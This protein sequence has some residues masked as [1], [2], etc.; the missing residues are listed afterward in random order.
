MSFKTV[1]SATLLASFALVATLPAQAGYY[2]TIYVEDEP[3]PVI[4]KE[5]V[6]APAPQTVI[7]Q[8]TNY[9]PTAYNPAVA[10]VGASALVGGVILGSVLH[11]HHKG[12]PRF[13]PAPMPHHGGPRPGGHK[14][15]APRHHR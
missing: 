4:I 7:V 13:M 3:Q 9:V 6:Q 11:N 14:G 2:K 10:V 5:V 8:E 12:G 1:V 15:P